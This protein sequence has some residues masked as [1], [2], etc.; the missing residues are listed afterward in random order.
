[1]TA[2]GS[3]HQTRRDQAAAMIR[4]L[5]REHPG[6][7][8][9]LRDDP[10]TVLSG[11]PG[12]RVVLADES[13]AGGN[14]SIAGRYDDE[15]VPPTLVVGAARSHRRRGF[16]VL[17][18]FGHHLQRT[19]LELG[20]PLVTTVDSEGLEEV[21][22]DEFASRVLLPDELIADEIKMRG[23]CANDVVDLF[24]SSQ[25]SR[26]ACCVR[27][28]NLLR[29]AGAVLLLDTAGSVLFASPRGLVPPAR[30]SDQ[31]RTPLIEAALRHRAFVQRDETF[32]IYRNGD[33]S[34]HVYGQAAWCDDDHLIAVVACD[35]VPWLSFALPRPGTQRSR[36]GTWW[37]CETP[38]C[39]DTFMITE[40][41]CERCAQ[42]RCGHGHC[43]CTAARA[44]LDREC[45][46]CRLT[47]PRR[48][49]DGATMVCRDCS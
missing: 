16:T 12:I 43:G 11:W 32:V 25:A 37:T 47:L 45:S 48:C 18:E 4:V 19:T 31:S 26:E 39:S 34:G 38:A 21:A 42:P 22:C 33:T 28:A 40:S 9:R 3:H 6:A 20:Q 27:A 41:P 29:G 7:V 46:G 10:L 35:N 13:S 24:D 30:G 49:F 36:F 2:R 44:Q 5:E 15:A 8:A 14:C 23:P 17:H 1:M